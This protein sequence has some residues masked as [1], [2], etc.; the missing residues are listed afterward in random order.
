MNN[1]R[2]PLVNDGELLPIFITNM[3]FFEHRAKT[4]EVNQQLKKLL[5]KV[6]LHPL[7]TVDWNW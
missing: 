4:S 1:P 3:I 2:N 7:L 5:E 6:V